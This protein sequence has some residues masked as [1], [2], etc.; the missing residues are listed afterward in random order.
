MPHQKNNRKKLESNWVQFNRQ[1][2]KKRL[3]SILSLAG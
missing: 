2:G 3:N 1:S